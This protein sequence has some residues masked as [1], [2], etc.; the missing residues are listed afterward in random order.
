MRDRLTISKSEL[1]R[2]L[3][4]FLCARE[5]K[6]NRAQYI[7]SSVSSSLEDT[8]WISL[9]FFSFVVFLFPSLFLPFSSFPFRLFSSLT[10]RIKN[11]L[12]IVRGINSRA[13]RENLNRPVD[14][15][16]QSEGDRLISRYGKIA[17]DLKIGARVAVAI[18]SASERDVLKD[19]RWNSGADDGW[20]RSYCRGAGGRDRRSVGD[21]RRCDRDCGDWRRKMEVKMNILQ[22]PTVRLRCCFFRL[23]Q[24]VFLCPFTFFRFAFSSLLS[25]FTSILTNRKVFVFF[26]F[27]YLEWQ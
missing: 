26:L 22:K 11:R 1:L 12:S 3:F 27:F 10:C 16:R 20:A 24:F 15:Q 25:V 21:Q 23:L 18:I 8:I 5:T 17:V 9:R 7:P 2:K 6:K 14:G 13:G 4:F 19:R